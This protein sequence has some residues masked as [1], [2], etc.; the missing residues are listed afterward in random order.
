[1][2]QRA[3]AGIGSRTT[4]FEIQQVMILAAQQLEPD[5]ILRSG[6]ADGAD[7]AFEM[8]VKNPDRKEI[9]IPWSGFNGRKPGP[10]VIRPHPNVFAEAKRVSS[11]YHPAWHK[12]SDT[13]RYLVARNALQVL[14][15]DLKT[16]SLFV[17]CWTPG[18]KGGGGTGQAIRIAKDHQIPVFDL[19]TGAF[20]DI[21][22]GI[23]DLL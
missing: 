5:L 7:T 11:R 6:G 9:F 10:G 23:N 22:A 8:G 15:P 18:G 17:L 21:A 2:N 13:V 20:D 19:G 16:P 3:Y 1:M 4:P 14:G 12:L